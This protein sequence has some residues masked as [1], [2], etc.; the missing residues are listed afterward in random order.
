MRVEDEA[1]QVSAARKKNKTNLRTPIGK[2]AAFI[3]FKQES[4]GK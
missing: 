1:A 4:I 2:Q 3:E